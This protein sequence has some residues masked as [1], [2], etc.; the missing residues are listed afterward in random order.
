MMASK[1]NQQSHLASNVVVTAAAVADSSPA[2]ATVVDK[3]PNNTADYHHNTVCKTAKIRK[4]KTKR[5]DADDPSDIVAT[6]SRLSQQD[7]MAAAADKS[8]TFNINHSTRKPTAKSGKS[9]A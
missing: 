8:S 1:S 2:C 5:N 9:R 6:L 3:H 7:T 4:T